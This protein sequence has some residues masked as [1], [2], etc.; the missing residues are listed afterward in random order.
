MG[1]HTEVPQAPR[2]Q[3][4]LEMETSQQTFR[5][6]WRSQ[7]A[8]TKKMLLSSQCFIREAHARARCFFLHFESLGPLSISRVLASTK[9]GQLFSSCCWQEGASRAGAVQERDSLLSTHTAPEALTFQRCCHRCRCYR[10]APGLPSSDSD[11]DQ[12][13]DPRTRLGCLCEG[14][15]R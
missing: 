4:V 15:S 6:T 14:S 7:I 9:A 1:A 5:R 13:A 2:A 3:A 11:S 12:T 8:E 10:A